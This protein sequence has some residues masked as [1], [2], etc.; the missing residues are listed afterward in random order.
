MPPGQVGTG[1]QSREPGQH[2]PG[3]STDLPYFQ[4]ECSWWEGTEASCC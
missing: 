3:F 1:W 4:L 2:L